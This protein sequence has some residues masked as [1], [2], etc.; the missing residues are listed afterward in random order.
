M[1]LDQTQTTF[2]TEPA[3][4]SDEMAA[5]IDAKRSAAIALLATVLEHAKSPLSTELLHTLTNCFR[6]V[7]E[8]VAMMPALPE[9]SQTLKATELNHLQQLEHFYDCIR[10]DCHLPPRTGP[11]TY[12]D[13]KECLDAARGQHNALNAELLGANV[14]VE[15]LEDA[16]A[17]KTQQAAQIEA[18][19]FAALD[20]NR[21]LSEIIEDIDTRLSVAF[22]KTTHQS[23]ISV[24]ESD[25]AAARNACPKNVS[26]GMI[27]A[28]AQRYAAIRELSAL[29]SSAPKLRAELEAANEEVASV[30]EQI[31]T[32]GANYD[33]MVKSRDAN[34]DSSKAAWK[35]LDAIRDRLAADGFSCVNV[36]AGVETALESLEQTQRERDQA[37]AKLDDPSRNRRLAELEHDLTDARAELAQVDAVLKY[38]RK[39]TTYDFEVNSHGR[40][41]DVIRS[42]AA[43]AEAIHRV[44][45]A[46]AKTDLD[47]LIHPAN[48][49]NILVERI[50]T[51]QGIADQYATSA[52]QLQLT[53]EQVQR[54]LDIANAPQSTS[55]ADRIGAFAMQAERWRVDLHVVQ[56]ENVAVAEALGLAGKTADLRTDAAKVVQERDALAKKLVS[57]QGALGIANDHIRLADENLRRALLL[58]PDGKAVSDLT[59]L[60][61]ALVELVAFWRRGAEPF[62]QAAE[63][64]EAPIKKILGESY[65]AFVLKL[66]EVLQSRKAAPENWDEHADDHLQQ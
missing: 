53:I 28:H 66:Q 42:L 10:F 23:S 52:M 4:P 9:I 8:S 33:D 65:G 45:D 22:Y 55:L 57:A 17:G 26:S 5:I 15:E 36:V 38:A 7:A 21:K 35:D 58:S 32:L 12:E 37:N 18:N 43:R 47:P 14:K 16:L 27:D 41:M 13:V 29:A 44:Q 2:H 6:N 50:T 30:R 63:A 46:L 19:L 25:L 60:M 31:K 20:E 11:V 34:V 49:V 54:A 24:L 59:D 3:P 40:R 62:R 61:Q 39:W 48:A 51:A 56:D 64:L 1:D